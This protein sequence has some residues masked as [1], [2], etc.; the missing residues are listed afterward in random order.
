MNEMVANKY[1]IVEFIG[2]GKFGNVF[3]GMHHKS[4]QFIAIKMETSDY[5][6]LKHETTMLNF[7]FRKGCRQIPT[8][9]WYGI[10]ETKPTLII[11]YYDTVFNSSNF[12]SRHFSNIISILSNIHKC[13]VIH[14]DIKTSNFMLKN[15]IVY[16]IDFGFATFYIDDDF[17]HKENSIKEYIIGTPAFISINIH[18]GNEASRRDDL[19]SLGYIYLYLNFGIE[20]PLNIDYSSM[21]TNNRNNLPL[22]DSNISIR[23][24]SNLE[25]RESKKWENLSKN[26]IFKQHTNIFNYLEYCYSL[27]YDETPDYNRLNLIL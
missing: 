8:I 1:K 27:K 10:H 4:K 3:K 2:N 5:K 22:C 7:L 24:P 11:S 15:D 23:H 18:N 12:S 13:G 21:F 6:I 16:L 26:E 19:I 20:N 9:F 14:R 17:K 25:R